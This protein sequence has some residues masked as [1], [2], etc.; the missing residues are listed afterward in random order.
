MVA[1]WQENGGAQYFPRDGIVADEADAK[2][3]IL[4]LR[5]CGL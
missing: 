4:S 3:R 5:T 1:A 2:G